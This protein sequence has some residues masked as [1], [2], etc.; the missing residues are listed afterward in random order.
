MFNEA[1]ID[2]K[3]AEGFPPNCGSSEVNKVDAQG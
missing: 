3:P 1:R 2:Q